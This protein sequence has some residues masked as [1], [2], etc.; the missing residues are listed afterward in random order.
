MAFHRKKY[1]ES[2]HQKFLQNPGRE[3]RARRKETLNAKRGRRIPAARIVRD[4]RR[5]TEHRR[6]AREIKDSY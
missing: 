3:N 4:E 5:R 6:I 2:L 1:E